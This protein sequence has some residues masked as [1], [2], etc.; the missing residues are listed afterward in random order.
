MELMEAISHR[1]S[2]R[3]YTDEPVPQATVMELLGAATW[4]PSAVNQQP[5][6]FG[7]IRGRRQLELYSERAKLHLLATLPQSLSLHQRSDQLT[8][9]SYNVFHRAGTLIVIFAKPAAHDPIEDCCLAAENLMLAAHGLGL[10]SCPIGFVRP[11]LNLPEIK[12]ELGIPLKYQAVMP[13]VIGWPSGRT[14]PVPRR[15]PEIVR[16]WEYPDAP[17][18]RAGGP[19]PG[20]PA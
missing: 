20:D 4:A 11:W 12:Y 8:S 13:V 19:A 10:G 2:V 16:W 17:S 1:R 18:S 7:V 15:E 9:S 6:A 5:W 14:A 3:T